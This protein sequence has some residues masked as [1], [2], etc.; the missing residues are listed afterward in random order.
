M[1]T[2]DLRTVCVTE[3]GVWVTILS[4]MFVGENLGCVYLNVSRKCWAFSL[5]GH[6]VCNILPPSHTHMATDRM[7][8]VS[9]SSLLMLFLLRC[10][11]ESPCLAT[12]YPMT[13]PAVSQSVHHL[14]ELPFSAH[15]MLI[16]LHLHHQTNLPF[17][18]GQ[19]LIKCGGV[20]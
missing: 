2:I 10:A 19:V 5:V 8:A 17:S 9:A 6:C 14:T 12:L 15:Q 11:G 7:K 18:V 16:T 4:Y 3:G 13:S 1:A 20:V